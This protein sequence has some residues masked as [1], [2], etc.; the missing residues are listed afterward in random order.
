MA[1]WTP[2]G[3]FGFAADGGDEVHQLHDVAAAVA[4]A[5]SQLVR[6]SCHRGGAKVSARSSRSV[7]EVGSGSCD[8]SQTLFFSPGA[9]ADS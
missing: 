7:Q 4:D 1:S 5:F 6:S 2:M 8:R 9:R 3:G